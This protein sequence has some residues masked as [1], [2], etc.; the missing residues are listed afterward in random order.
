NLERSLRLDGRLG[1][2]FVAGHV[3]GVGKVVDVKEL[4]GSKLVTIRV[5]E[6]LER[7]I[8][9]KGSIAVDGISL[10][11][12]TVEGDRFSVAI[13]PHTEKVT[14]FDTLRLGR[15]VN[16]EVDMLAKYIEKLLAAHNRGGGGLTE[17]RLRELGYGG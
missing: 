15:R 16:L 17:E 13:I 14:T 12:T 7:Y 9:E 8:V 3:D 4:P 10:T 5:S 6:G 2:H 1:G 11:V